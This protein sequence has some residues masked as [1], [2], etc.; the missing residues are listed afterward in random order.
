MLT[1]T[2]KRHRPRS[3]PT[4]TGKRTLITENDIFGIF[5]PLSRYA[6]LTTKQL[7]AFDQRYPTKTRA[8]L[9]DLFHANEG[10]LE[11]LSEDV[12][13]ANHLFT[14]E[15]YRLGTEAKALLK[16]RGIIPSEPWAHTTQVGGHSKVP[17]RILRLAHDHMACDVALDI[18]IGA[19]RVGVK[20]HSHVDLLRNAPLATRLLPNPLRIP[21]PYGVTS[22]KWIEPDALFAI[23]SRVY[24][25][26]ADRG[27]ESIETIIK[28]K[29]RAYRELVAGYIIDDHLGIDNLTVLFVATTE[30][31]MRSMMRAVSEIAKN[32]RSKMFAFAC[33]PELADFRRAPAPC[34]R[35]F[36]EPWQRAGYDEFLF[37]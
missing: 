36:R 21:V 35:M 11:R 30:S 12:R 37:I 28:G 19:R 29:I 9:T 3:V 27:T 4:P 26:E 14:D 8:R 10:W 7:V 34:G 6:Q 23:R 17:S 25:L 22:A 18:E 2:P 15:F 1:V 5:E 13:F 24:A 33:R 31:R 20:Y 16:S 32:G